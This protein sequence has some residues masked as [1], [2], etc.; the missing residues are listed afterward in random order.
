MGYQT[1]LLS[2]ET[3]PDVVSLFTGG[4]GG[5]HCWCVWCQ[6]DPSNRP[7]RP[8]HRAGLAAWGRARKK[9]L[10][11]RGRTRGV[12]VYDGSEPVGWCHFGTAEEFPGLPD[13][14]ASAGGASTGT[15]WLINCF[16]V[17]KPYRQQGVATR[18]LRAALEAIVEAGGAVVRARPAVSWTHGQGSSSDVA[19]V[20]GLGPIAPAW[21]SFS[22]VGYTGTVS[23]FVREGFVPLGVCG[24]RPSTPR[25]RTLGAVGDRVVM[26][27]VLGR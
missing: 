26:Q 6:L 2:A 9:E 8:R 27:K 16:V 23:M 15:E 11:D 5:D 25:L 3:W 12:L 4:N 13:V 21:G 14:V 20:G 19:F 24:T 18:A 22:G 10:L 1:R 7:K 17:A